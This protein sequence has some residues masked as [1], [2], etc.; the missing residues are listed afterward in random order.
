VETIED[1]FAEEPGA[2]LARDRDVMLAL[3]VDEEHVVAPFGPAHIHVFAQLDVALRAQDKR[4]PVAPGAQA[5]GRQPIDADLAGRTVVADQR[6][7]AKILKL[8]RRGIRKMP[9]AASTTFASE[10]PL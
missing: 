5:V 10:A 4:P 8:R 1:E 2:D 7:L 9:T 6:G 3:A